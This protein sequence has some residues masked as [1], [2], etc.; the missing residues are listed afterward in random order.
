MAEGKW[1]AELPLPGLVRRARRLADMSQR[2]MA[3]AA[4]VSR[5]T[6]GKIEAGTLMPSVALLQRVL[7]AAKLSLVVVDDEGHVVKPMKD[8]PDTQDGAG[9]RYPSHLDLV[10][11]PR[12][13]D[14]WA[15]EYGLTAPPETFRRS[16]AMRD[17]QRAR[18]QWEVRVAKLRHVPPP[19]DPYAEERRRAYLA[20]YKRGSRYRDHDD[21]QAAVRAWWNSAAARPESW[22]AVEAEVLNRRFL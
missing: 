16:R 13:G 2:E 8:W 20:G 1:P 3:Q 15:D 18:S 9:R 22:A 4:E 11:I 7:G 14:W 12:P 19:P 6:I 5:S 21:Q 17:M 10:L